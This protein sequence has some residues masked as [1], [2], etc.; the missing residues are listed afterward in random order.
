VDYG[1]TL[2][3]VSHD[4]YFVERLASKIVEVGSGSGALYPGTYT[5]FLWRKEHP[6][7][8][9]VRGT[10]NPQEWRQKH[11]APGAVTGPVAPAAQP[12]SHGAPQRSRE[13][14]K[15][16]DAGARRKARAEH[17]RRARIDQLES[18]IA[19]TEQAIREI[20]MAMAAPG[21]YD[22]RSAAQPVIDR[23]QALMWRVGEL[24]H[25]WEELQAAATS[26]A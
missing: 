10:R 19:E 16:A 25:Q 18:H 12:R 4:R 17:A 8:P 11:T 21:F 15:R 26:D 6:Q 5:E 14:T 7:G 13:L 2:V 20:E 3:F 24:M 22:D 9:G 23:H 1:G